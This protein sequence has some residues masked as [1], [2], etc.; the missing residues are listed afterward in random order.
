M[1]KK[2]DS[3]VLPCSDGLW[4]AQVMRRGTCRGTTIEREKIGF[5]TQDLAN[6]WAG[7]Q[8]ELYVAQRKRKTA[9][10]SSQ[11]KASRQR[12]KERQEALNKMSLQAL[13]LKS[14]DEPDC[15]VEFKYQADLLFQDVAFRMLKDGATEKEAFNEANSAVGKTLAIRLAKAKDGLLDP[16]ETGVT[17][18]AIENAKA[19][20]T[21]ALNTRFE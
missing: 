20:L 8:L 19:L 10:R 17:L 2:F 15:L 12:K 1:S 14:T 5:A 7:E 3:R 18:L 13:A 16:V 11:R 9:A 21:N 6:K 4:T